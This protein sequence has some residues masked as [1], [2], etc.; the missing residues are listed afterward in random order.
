MAFTTISRSVLAVVVALV[1]SYCLDWEVQAADMGNCLLCHKYPGLSRVDETG[2]MK[3]MFVNEDIFNKS[4]HS[5]VKCEGCH[6]D[7]T[8]IPHD[9]AKPVDCL[10]ECHIVEPTSEQKFSHREVE[11]YLN[12]SVHAKTDEQGNLKK[13]SEDMPTCKDC[14]DN[15]LFRPLAFVKK[16]RPGI[17]EEAMGRCRVCHKKEDFIF[18]FYNHITTRMHKSRSPLNIAQ[19]CGKCHDDP[20]LVARHNLKTKAGYSYSETFHGKAANLLDESVPDC[21]DCHVVKG[22]SV[23]QMYG[24]DDPR[25][26]TYPANREQI[27]NSVDCH[28]GASVKFA[29]YKVHAEYSRI[30]NPVI[31]W[32]TTFFIILT[33]GTLLP[34]MGIMF[35]DLLRRLFPNA[36]IMRR[37]K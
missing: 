13:Y 22:T 25:S 24:N 16:V 19:A 34:L 29:N 14:H 33:G 2:R 20:E 37:R 28:P 35:L 30:Q 4:V 7:I 10:T 26:S 32:F 1:V 31:Y 36:T 18:R 17:A 3:L 23:H 12:D 11:K 21:L 15:P 5:K 8:K 27:C 9:P 6:T